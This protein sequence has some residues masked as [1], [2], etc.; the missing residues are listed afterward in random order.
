MSA[1]TGQ[2]IHDTLEAIVHK[3][4]APTGTL[5][6]PLKAMLVDSWYDA[7]LGVIVLVRIMDGTL[8]KGER[9]KFMSNGT[10]HH[11]D[12]IGVFRPAMQMVE[13]LRKT[14]IDTPAPFSNLFIS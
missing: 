13:D 6:A 4:P 9:V 11:V 14:I 8:K 10:I 5:D 2:G 7:Y 3:L 12:R 1:K